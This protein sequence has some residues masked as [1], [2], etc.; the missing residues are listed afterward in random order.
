MR[1]GGKSLLF[2]EQKRSKK[3]FNFFDVTSAGVSQVLR[4]AK[5]FGAFFQKSTSSFFLGFGSMP[6]HS[7]S[8][9]VLTFDLTGETFALGAILVR[10]VLDECPET[11]VPGAPA[12]V[13]AVI[14]FRGR[15]IPLADLRL[16]FGLRV[17]PLTRDSRVIV[18]EFNRGGEAMLIGLRADKVFE[19][20]MIPATATEPPPRL[21]TRWP[22]DFIEALAKR[23][24]EVI[25][26]PKLDKIFAS[27][28]TSR[29]AAPAS[30]QNAA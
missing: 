3:N 17:K 24:G 27:C 15:I 16:A 11:H 2:C 30:G 22:P 28:G 8:L 7:S 21:G 14:N 20:T 1:K 13:D 6:A 5:V 23:D 25:V 18:I 4:G 12:F 10:E 9:E 26:L 19:V 29:M